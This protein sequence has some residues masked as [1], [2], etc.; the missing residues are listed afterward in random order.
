[1]INLKNS[2]GLVKQC[3]TGFSWTMLFFGG[4]VPLLRGDLKWFAITFIC[5]ICTAGLAWLVFPFIYNKIYIKGL[6]TQGFQ[7][8]DDFSKATLQQMGVYIAK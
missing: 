6:L 5:A 3:P 8:A 7:P 2:I 4:F 1:M